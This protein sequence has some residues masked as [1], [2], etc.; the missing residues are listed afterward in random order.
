VPKCKK[1]KKKKKKPLSI[2]KKNLLYLKFA[3]M[4]GDLATVKKF[5]GFSFLLTK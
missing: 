2:A 3:T 5:I 4:V 1:K